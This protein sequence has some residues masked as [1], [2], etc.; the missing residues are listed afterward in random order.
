M[1]FANSRHPK[2]SST[3]SIFKIIEYD[4]VRVGWEYHSRVVLTRV[5]FLCTTMQCQVNTLQE[6][7]GN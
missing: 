1:L 4:S 6:P 2:L 3:V 5:C 7:L